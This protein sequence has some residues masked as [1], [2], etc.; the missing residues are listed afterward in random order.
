MAVTRGAIYVVRDPR[1]VAVSVAS[2]NAEPI[3]RAIAR[4][5]DPDEMLSGSIARSIPAS[6][7]GVPS[8]GAMTSGTL[9]SRVS[10]TPMPPNWP[11]VTA[12]ICWYCS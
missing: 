2:S 6:A 5:D 11:R 7:A 1:A 3:D 4:M 10:S 8:S 9:A 12:V